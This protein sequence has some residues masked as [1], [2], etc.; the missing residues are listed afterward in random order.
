M[1]DMSIE[2]IVSNFEDSKESTFFYYIM[3]LDGYWLE[4]LSF[5]L[6]YNKVHLELLRC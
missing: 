6:Q 5:M 4:Y 2:Q 3:S 1:E